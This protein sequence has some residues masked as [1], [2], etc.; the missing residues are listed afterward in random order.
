LK[1]DATIQEDI[2]NRR[3]WE[4]GGYGKPE[5]IGPD[6]KGNRRI[7]ETEG[8]ENMETIRY[9]KM[10]DMGNAKILEPDTRGY[11]KVEDTVKIGGCGKP[12]DTTR[13]DG[14]TELTEI[15]KIFRGVWAWSRAA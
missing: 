1:P 10:E 11:R 15:L 6:L 4:N 12:K 2:G 14:K 9:G 7:R 3:A 13:G 5:D 8:Y